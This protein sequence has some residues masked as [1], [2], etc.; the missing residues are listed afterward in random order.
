MIPVLHAP[1]FSQLDLDELAHGIARCGI[2]SFEPA[3]Q[4]VA[5]AAERAGACSVLVTLLA[6][7]DSPRVAR[8][9]AFGRLA[10][11]LVRRLRDAS[12]ATHR[13]CA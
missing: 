11:V 12:P 8:E 3:V 1:S 13:L 2:T 6:D 9:R 7:Q 10:S 5:A 4:A